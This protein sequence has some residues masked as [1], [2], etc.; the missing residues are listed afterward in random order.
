MFAGLF[1]DLL[2]LS[3]RTVTVRYPGEET[4]DRY[5]ATIPGD[6]QDEDVDNVLYV[7]TGTEDLE[8][9]RPEGVEVVATF[10]F[11]KDYS[12]DLQGCRILYGGRDYKVIGQP[13]HYLPE[14]VPSR[15]DMTVECEDYDG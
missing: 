14:N 1:D 12:R 4:Q 10:C 15:W 2:L 5:G 3:G 9:S 7:P 11:P 8:A 6:W 13:N